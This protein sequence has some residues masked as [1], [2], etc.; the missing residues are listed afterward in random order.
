LLIDT[1]DTKLVSWRRRKGIC[2]S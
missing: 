2:N 1:A